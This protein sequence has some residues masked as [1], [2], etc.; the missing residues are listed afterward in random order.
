MPGHVVLIGPYLIGRVLKG[1]WGLM[2][3]TPWTNAHMLFFVGSDQGLRTAESLFFSRRIHVPSFWIHRLLKGLSYH[4]LGVY[5]NPNGPNTQIQSTFPKLLLQFLISKPYILH[6]WVLWTLGKRIPFL[7]L[8]P[9]GS[10]NPVARYLPKTSYGKTLNAIHL[11]FWTI[12]TR[13]TERN[14]LYHPEG[15]DIVPVWS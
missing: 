1:S 6:I 10:R 4:K 5:S 11:V 9:L 3:K 14:Q 2:E 7:I 12:G 8:I 13:F 15:L